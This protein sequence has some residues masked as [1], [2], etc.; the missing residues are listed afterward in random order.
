MELETNPRNTGIALGINPCQSISGHHAHLR[1]SLGSLI[2]LL[3]VLGWMRNLENPEE[4]N[5]N[6]MWR[7]IPLHFVLNC[8]H[9]CLASCV[10]IIPHSVPVS[11]FISS[12]FLNSLHPIRLSSRW[13]NMFRYVLF[14]TN[15]TRGKT[16]GIVI[17][18]A[19]CFLRYKPPTRFPILP[20][21]PNPTP[22][23]PID[24]QTKGQSWA[25]VGGGA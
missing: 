11:S 14:M 2:H 3:A 20:L 16:S 25:G 24:R 6:A 5:M 17:F 13:R 10:F 1:G 19:R 9:F 7:C 18:R 23:L 12:T 4:T 15:E 8:I 22:R 21:P